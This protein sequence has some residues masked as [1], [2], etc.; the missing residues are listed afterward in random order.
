MALEKANRCIKKLVSLAD[1]KILLSLWN[2]S[3]AVLA[4][5]SDGKNWLE[6]CA[7][8]IVYWHTLIIASRAPWGKHISGKWNF[9]NILKIALESLRKWVCQWVLCPMCILPNQPVQAH[10]KHS[11]LWS[12]AISFWK[13]VIQG[14]ASQ[15]SSQGHRR[16]I[17]LLR[18]DGKCRNEMRYLVYLSV[19]FIHH[20]EVSYLGSPL[21]AARRPKRDQLACFILF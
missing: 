12:P 2:I 6:K 16:K 1:I 11:C 10:W 3:L 7:R 5:S 17:L 14:M 4:G 19:E 9:Y 13:Q 18:R 20:V 8:N 21:E 15:N